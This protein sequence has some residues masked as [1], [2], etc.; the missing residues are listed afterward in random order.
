MKSTKSA[1]FLCLFLLL[2]GLLTVP[3]SAERS[4]TADWNGP[5][6]TKIKKITFPEQSTLLKQTSSAPIALQTTFANVIDSP[7]VAGFVPWVVLVFTD[8]R[9]DDESWQAIVEPSLAGNLTATP[10]RDKYALGIFDTG[11]SASVLGYENANITGIYNTNYLTESP[12]SVTGVTG[13]VEAIVSQPLG[14]FIKGLSALDPNSP[15]D[16]QGKLN[17]T[18]GF[19]GQSNV[20]II[21]GDYPDNRPDLISAV[22]SPFSV[23]YTTWLRNDHPI[24]TV[25]NGQTYTGPDIIIY[26]R[27]DLSAPSYKNKLPLELR[28]LGASDVQYTITLDDEFNIIP[29]SPSI[30]IGNLSQSLF[31]V[32]SVDLAEGSYSAIDKSRFMLDTGAQITIIGSRIAAR[33]A[34]DPDNPEFTVD[35]QGVTGDSI[36]APGFVLDSIR[37]PALGQWLQFSN[38][39]VV[40]LDIFS[41]EGGTLDGIIG[42]NLFTQYNLILRGGGFMLQD[43]PVL[44]FEL[45][46][47]SITGD[48]AP[49]PDGDGKVDILD[50][51]LLSKLWLATPSSPDWIQKADVVPDGVINIYDLLIFAEH[52]LTSL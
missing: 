35:I 33:L 28:P 5:F 27:D 12:V 17:S 18:A 36:M 19:K 46:S 2:T 43:D 48:I 16:P 4:D 26:D 47:S 14:I 22:G 3:A 42:M 34:L 38:V 20:S 50:L 45:I 40:M 10:I 9:L 8:K 1:K 52:W 15:T 21:V 39:P 24:S 41:P 37:I 32:H 13:S 23:Y 31:F 29:A 6:G 30:I 49:P 25:R 7:P 11:A 44:E 51:A